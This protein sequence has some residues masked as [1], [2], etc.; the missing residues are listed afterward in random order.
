MFVHEVRITAGFDEFRDRARDYILRGLAPDQVRFLA[1]ESEQEMDLLASLRNET[2]FDGPAKQGKLTVPPAYLKLAKTIAHHASPRRWDLLYRILWRLQKES[3]QLLELAIDDDVR[4]A[5]LMQK[6]IHR[7]IHKVHAFVRFEKVPNQEGEDESYFAWIETEHPVIELAAPFFARR[8]GDRRWS[9]LTPHGSAFWDG[10]N[11]TFGE[12]VATPPPR[13]ESLDDLWKAYYRSSFNPARIKMKA[14]RAEMPL[15]YWKALPETEII[16]ELIRT[17]PDRL[18][19]M[20]ERQNRRAEPPETKDL[21]HLKFAARS[22]QACPLFDSATQTVFGEGPA[23]SRLMII[24]EQPGDHEDQVGRPFVGPAGEVFD[25]AMKKA[26]IARSSAYITNSVKHFKW[27]PGPPGKLRLHQKPSGS[28]MHA[29]R[30][31]LER[32][33]EAIRPD[34]IVCM[35]QTAATV[36]FG[37]AVRLADEVGKIHTHLPWA[38]RILVTYHPSAILRAMTEESKQTMLNSLETTLALARE[39]VESEVLTEP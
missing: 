32:E 8:F 29:C 13:A 19:Q 12:G 18:S 21:E 28:E 36:L 17:A 24:G 39:C 15:K 33:I 26:G 34:V 9:I 11:L 10:E 30:P 35:G 3:R 20:A 31:W 25:R 27:K 23:T 38:P 6:A 1:G 14:M 5:T 4:E 37:R 7:E 16:N 2:A 22:C